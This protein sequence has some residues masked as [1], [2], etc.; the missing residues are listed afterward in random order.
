MIGRSSNVLQ[1]RTCSSSNNPLSYHSFFP[2]HPISQHVGSQRS[3]PSSSF[4]IA[5]HLVEDLWKNSIAVDGKLEVGDM[6]DVEC[7][8][9]RYTEGE[10]GQDTGKVERIHYRVV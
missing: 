1:P 9:R 2:C 7:R 4:A 8:A 5:L 10:L 6:V 3:L